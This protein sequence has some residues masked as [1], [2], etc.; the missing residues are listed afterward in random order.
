MRINTMQ[1][2]ISNL[3][4]ALL[5]SLMVFP[6]CR[7]FLDENPTVFVTPEALLQDERGAEKYVVGAYNSIRVL[8]I[9]WSGWTSM[10]GNLGAD[11]I[12]VPNWGGDTKAIYL[13]TLAPSTATVG[14]MWTNCYTSVNQLNSV[15]DRISAMNDEQ[16]DPE[17]RNQFVGEARYLR[18]MV[19][20]AMVCTWE[21]IPLVTNET[22][23][24]EGLEVSQA[25][26][27]E[28]YDFIIADL[29]FAESVLPV[30]QGN[31]RATQG[32]AQ[33]LLGKVYLQMTGF[34][35]NQTDKYALAEEKLRS[36]MESGVY[37]L[38]A[39]YP[40]VFSLDHEQNQEILFAIGFDGPG[41][42]QGGRLGTFYGPNG[43]ADLG[44]Q[45]GNNFFVNWEL[46]GNAED[47]PVGSG[48][49]P[50]R[51]NFAYAQGYH[52]DDIRCRNNIAKHNVN[53]GE[54]YPEDG[55]YNYE[56]RIV[57]RPW[58]AATW[59]AWKW[60]NIR[61]SNWGG[62]DSPYD[63]PYLRYADVLLM[64]AEA[65]NG[66]NKL[67]QE[68]IDETVNRLRARA[69]VFPDQVMP[70][71]VAAPMVLGTQQDNAYEIL[72]ERR[73]E[74]CFEGWRRNDLIRFGVYAEAISNTQP[75]WSN[76]GN[77]AVQFEPHEIRWPIP[78]S[79]LQLNPNLKQNP[80][81]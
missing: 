26:P 33:G 53:F 55:M 73:K 43:R 57:D 81:Y 71:S 29:L 39:F 20:F 10:W 7:G 1:F 63:Q 16:I 2:K 17:V 67:T 76:S 41:R 77:P 28:V 9:D 23:S 58:L 3:I 66:Q 47:L 54:W 78:L 45:S 6:G 79:E 31:G 36:V 4:V 50:A 59:K 56:A 69:R 49:W 74:L 8:A 12:V 15:V 64:Y 30:E 22:L 62:N 72:S 24:F 52:E 14:N 27:E 51:N 34:P 75:A 37:E 80:G 25:T 68:N 46:A 48:T 18:A 60:H 32:A 5:I 13:H 44:G 35:L 70:D 11:E 21:N 42:G 61:P 38:M 65:L 19:Y 40:D